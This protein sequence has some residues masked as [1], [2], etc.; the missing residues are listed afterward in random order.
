MG[1]C[2]ELA[3]FSLQGGCLVYFGLLTGDGH[4]LLGQELVQL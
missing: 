3:C 2:D 1:V 4:H